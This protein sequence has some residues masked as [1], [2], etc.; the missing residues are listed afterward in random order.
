V[1]KGVT[2]IEAVP[3]EGLL[4]YCDQRCDSGCGSRSVCRVDRS[5]VEDFLEVFCSSVVR[6]HG[7]GGC[8]ELLV[9]CED[10]ENEVEDC[11]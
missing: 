9:G 11:V 8:L 6:A 4:W 10:E 3:F 5:V 1:C 2:S 7:G